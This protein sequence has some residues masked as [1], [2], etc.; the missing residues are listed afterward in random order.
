MSLGTLFV[1]ER[2]AA[3]GGA[4]CLRSSGGEKGG[5]TSLEATP[6]L[7]TKQGCRYGAAIV[8]TPRPWVA[9]TRLPFGSSVS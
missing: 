7:V 5:V 4:L 2:V 1:T 6:L 3:H 9:A 8:Q